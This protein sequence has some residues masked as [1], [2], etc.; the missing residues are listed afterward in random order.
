MLFP[1]VSYRLNG[2]NYLGIAGAAAEVA[3]DGFSD[4]GFGRGWV[5][6]EESSGTQDHSGGAETALDGSIVEEGLLEGRES[7]FR[8]DSFNGGDLAAFTLAGQNQAGVDRPSVKDDG[9]GT[10]FTDPAAFFGTGEME[11]LPEE[12]E[13]AEVGIYL[14]CVFLA[15]NRDV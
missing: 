3:G 12:I 2:F 7:V 11:V 5:M 14:E 8:G 4:L 1:A 15:V 10:A 6:I 9:A 13:E